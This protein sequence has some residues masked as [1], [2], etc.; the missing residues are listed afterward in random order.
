MEYTRNEAKQWAQKNLRG[1]YDAPLTPFTKSGE[2]D[3]PALRDNI[4]QFVDMGLDGIV[5]GGFIAAMLQLAGT[6]LALRTARSISHSFFSHEHQPRR[7]KRV[8]GSARRWA[9]RRG[10]WHF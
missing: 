9:D 10:L 4:D 8:R 6:L 5:V 7:R 2:L 1:F 3:E